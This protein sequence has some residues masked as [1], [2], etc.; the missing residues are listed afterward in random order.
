MREYKTVYYRRVD[1]KWDVRVVAGNGKT[2]LNS[3]QG[4]ENLGDVQAMANKAL[5]SM[6]ARNFSLDTSAFD[7]RTETV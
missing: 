6:I 1:G 4:Y 2:V 7:E 3:D 5:D